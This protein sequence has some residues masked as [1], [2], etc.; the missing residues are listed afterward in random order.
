[1]ISVLF[2]TV[3]S[4]P[5]VSRKTGV[6]GRKIRPVAIIAA[7]ISL[8]REPSFH[9]HARTQP[10]LIAVNQFYGIEF[11]GYL[12][13][14]SQQPPA[15]NS[16]DRAAGHGSGRNNRETSNV[17][18]SHDDKI[19]RSPTRAWAEETLSASRSS[20]GVP[21]GMVNLAGIALISWAEAQGMRNIVSRK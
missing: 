19:Q 1:M 17:H 12:A 18:I 5:R 8:V 15:L 6:A 13:S 14:D 3:L 10:D 9:L 16:S 2:T 20:M 21:S 7:A 4:W 11:Q